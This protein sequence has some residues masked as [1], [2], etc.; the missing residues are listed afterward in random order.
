MD[1][2]SILSRRAVSLQP[3]GIR[4]FFDMLENRKDVVAL[5]VG[6]PDF[7]TPWHIREAGIR[8]LEE[9]RTYYTSNSGLMELRQE[10]SAYALRRFSLTYDP[11]DE[12]I[13]TVGGSEAIDLALRAVID[14]GDEV[15]VPQPSFVCYD[16]LVTMAAGNP[17]ILPLK[18]E[19]GFVL[20]GEELEKYITPRTKAVILP[21]PN[22]PTGSIMRKEQ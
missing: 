16:P 21:F 3:S 7:I 18:K 8:S 13:V 5:T 9:G 11:K 6:Q 2:T 10:I 20:T 22:N 14:P 12:I 4:K 15:I 17:V 19:N 1:Y